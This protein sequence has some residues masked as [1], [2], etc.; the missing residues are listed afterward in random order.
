VLDTSNYKLLISMSVVSHGQLELISTLLDTIPHQVH[1]EIEVILTLNLPEDESLLSVERSFKTVV[2]RND[3]PKG[4]GANHNSAFKVSSGRYFAVVN[5]DI[6]LVENPFDRL[7]TV[8]QH[9]EVGLVSPEIIDSI[10]RKQDSCRKFPT[11]LQ[12]LRRRLLKVPDYI[13]IPEI[14]SPQ[15]VGG[16][17]MLF[18]RFAYEAVDGFD[19]NFFMYCEDADI[20]RRLS[21]MGYQVLQVG[22]AKVIHDAQRNSH[23]NLRHLKWH[24]TSLF[25]FNV[26]LIRNCPSLTSQQ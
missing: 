3:D 24:I 1:K 25:R 11:I 16:M 7:I 26:K 10:G 14:F 2:I 6:V 23:R 19:E 21:C 18:Q 8:L 12:L 13:E 22:G 5:P 15:W 9:P 4:F 17:F 20:C